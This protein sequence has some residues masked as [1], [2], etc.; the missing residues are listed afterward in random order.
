VSGLFIFDG[1][2]GLGAGVEGRSPPPISEV[3][4]KAFPSPFNAGLVNLVR[5]AFPIIQRDVFKFWLF[6]CLHGFV[7]G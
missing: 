2:V 4:N 7:D 6:E 1:H 3:D 5:T